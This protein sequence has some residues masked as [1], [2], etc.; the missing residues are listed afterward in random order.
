MENQ[1]KAIHNTYINL[2]H[3]YTSSMDDNEKTELGRR[4]VNVYVHGDYRT[5]PFEELK[6]NFMIGICY[7]FQKKHEKS[8]EYLRMAIDEENAQALL[9]IGDYYFS[10][11]IYDS[12]LFHYESSVACGNDHALVSIGK[13]YKHF[14]DY[15]KAMSKFVDAVEYNGSYAMAMVQIGDLYREGCG[16][17][18]DSNKASHYYLDA[19]A[20]HNI[21]AMDRLGSHFME[22]GLFGFAIMYWEYSKLLGSHLGYSKLGYCYI[23]GTGVEKDVEKGISYYR[24][25]ESLGYRCIELGLCYYNG[26]GVDVDMFEA[27]KRLYDTCHRSLFSDSDIVE[28]DGRLGNLS[29]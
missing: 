5:E 17:D 7:G 21:I 1:L 8:I 3:V 9:N 4:I 24:V 19:C 16:V 22:N 2:D 18:A 23:S 26:V 6:N 13:Y 10:V 25:V 11:E 29:S 12:A 27:Y 15:E 14:G 28:F 20:Q